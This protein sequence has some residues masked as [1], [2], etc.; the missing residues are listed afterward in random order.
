MQSDR[1]LIH[2]H[3]ICS[4]TLK[5]VERDQQQISELK[6][7]YAMHRLLDDLQKMLHREMQIINSQMYKERIKFVK[8]EVKDEY[9]T[10]YM[11]TKNKIESEMTYSNHA[12]QSFVNE[13]I[14]NLINFNKLKFEEMSMNK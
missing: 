13:A 12:L 2:K 8:Y 5:S 10:K 6:L 1:D 3:I 9:F 4:L 14:S 7:K 11:Y